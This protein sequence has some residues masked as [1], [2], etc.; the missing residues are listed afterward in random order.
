MMKCHQNKKED[1]A[2]EFQSSCQNE[3]LD[4]TRYVDLAKKACRT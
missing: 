4:S 2:N 3:Y 1:M